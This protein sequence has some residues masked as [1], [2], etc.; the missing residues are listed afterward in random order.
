MDVVRIARDLGDVSQLLPENTSLL[1]APFNLVDAIGTTLAFLSMEEWPLEDRPP[2]RIWFNEKAMKVHWERVKAKMR[3]GGS[4][5][6]FDRP[7]DG[8]YEENLA[9]SDLISYG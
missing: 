1:D 4:D 8:P 9:A 6:S 2:R 5:D 7:I 3:S